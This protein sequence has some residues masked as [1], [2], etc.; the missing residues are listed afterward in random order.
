MIMMGLII[1]AIAVSAPIGAAVLVSVASRRED[2]AWTL[3]EAAPGLGESTARRILGV[4]CQGIDWQQ[5]TGTTRAGARAPSP[6]DADP[7]DQAPLPGDRPVTAV[8]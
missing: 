1:A 6:D 2:R 4:H 5:L 7:A 8:R 3:T